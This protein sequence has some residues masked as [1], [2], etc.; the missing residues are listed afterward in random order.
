MIDI[1]IDQC[2]WQVTELI[3]LL[4][5]KGVTACAGGGQFKDNL[6]IWSVESKNNVKS[7]Y[8]FSGK[9]SAYDG[10]SVRQLKS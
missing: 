8:F 10:P 1:N 5:E 2:I 6:L 4:K 7:W 3:D 9:S